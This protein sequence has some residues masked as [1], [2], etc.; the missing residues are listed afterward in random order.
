MTVG[1]PLSTAHLPRPDPRRGIFE[2][3]LV[4]DGRPVELD[5][6][7]DRLAASARELFGPPAMAR[8]VG[9]ARAL[10]EETC[11]GGPMSHLTRLRITLSP[12]DRGA[13]DLSVAIAAVEAAAV[14]PAAEQGV[15]LAPVTV[16]GGLG[17]HKW[18]DRRLL[19]SVAQALDG[20]LPLVVDAAAHALEAERANVF[21]LQGGCLVTPPDDGQILP[22][23]ARRRTIDLALDLGIEVEERPIALED[24]QLA[25]E[26]FLTGSVRGI[27]PVASVAGRPTPSVRAEGPIAPRLA[28]ALRARWLGGA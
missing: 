20:G 27:E 14:F 16:A 23:I 2:T 10:V 4:V 17:R 9:P 25:D 19:E 26:V 6:H 11:A 15:A 28:E 7:L 24:L 8:V 12:D 5:A 18:A 21:A 22:G 1:S 3:L 13:L